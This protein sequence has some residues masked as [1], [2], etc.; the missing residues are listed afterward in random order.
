M[1]EKIKDEEI[2]WTKGT[3]SKYDWDNWFDGDTWV[4]TQGEDFQTEVDTFQTTCLIRSRKRFGQGHLRTQKI[5]KNKIAI[6]K[7]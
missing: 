7:I 1:A 3:S 4:L 6:Q 2:T 5:N